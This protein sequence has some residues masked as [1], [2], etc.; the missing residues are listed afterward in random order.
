MAGI[1]GANGGARISRAAWVRVRRAALRTHL[2]IP[3][4]FYSEL[5]LS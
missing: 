5:Q 2:T 4:L 3:L 1:P